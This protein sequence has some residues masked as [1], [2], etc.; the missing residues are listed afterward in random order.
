M[1]KKIVNLKD[2]YNLDVDT[3]LDCVIINNHEEI[4][5]NKKRKAIIILPGGGYS[6]VSKR[7]AMP[8]ARKFLAN[9]N[10]TFIL[11]YATS[12]KFPLPMLQVF[13]AIDYIQKNK[14]D[15][16]IDKILLCGFSAGGHLAGITCKL[17]ED[18]KYLKLIGINNLHLDGVILNYPVVDFTSLAHEGSRDNL[19]Q[20]DDSLLD[21]L[22]VQKN[23]KKFP[24]AFIWHTLEDVVVHPSNSIELSRSLIE[25]NSFH[26]L[27][28]FPKGK[29][30][31]ALANHIT[32]NS[33]YE[34]ITPESEKWMELCL[35]FINN[36]I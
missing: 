15:F 18:K 30:G 29:H 24:K 17:L 12:T 1:I 10:S 4:D 16:N 7:E 9:D 19:T 26:E 22:S 23:L 28:L 11:N 21:L 33:N 36:N 25:I 14:D 32:N 31:L 20:G 27:H 5:I 34:T 13:A 2:F 3:F 35:D 8:I 6:M